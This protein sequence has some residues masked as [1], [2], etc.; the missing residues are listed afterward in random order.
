MA[1]PCMSSP[2]VGKP[3]KRSLGS[4]SAI[5]QLLRLPLNVHCERAMFGRI[6]GAD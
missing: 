1:L 3:K 4:S 2:N 6:A 5:A